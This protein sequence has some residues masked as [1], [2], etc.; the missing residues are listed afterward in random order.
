MQAIPINQKKGCPGAW[1]FF[2]ILMFMENTPEENKSKL[3]SFRIQERRLTY[4]S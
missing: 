2:G 1:R 4:R 3:S